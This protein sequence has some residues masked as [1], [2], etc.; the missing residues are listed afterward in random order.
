MGRRE[1]FLGT[2][3]INGADWRYGWEESIE[4]SLLTIKDIDEMSWVCGLFL[5]K[6]KVVEVGVAAVTVEV[7]AEVIQEVVAGTKKVGVIV[8][9]LDEGGGGVVTLR[10]LELTWSRAWRRMLC[11]TGLR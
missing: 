7:V 8:A 9:V 3:R 2:N 4:T 5:A 10:K 6:V 11:Q 1:P